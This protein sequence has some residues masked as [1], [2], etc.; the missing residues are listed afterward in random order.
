MN[1]KRTTLEIRAHWRGILL[2][3]LIVWLLL[4]SAY[5][6]AL[7]PSPG[8]TG[9]DFRMYYDAAARVMHREPLYV[10]EPS[11][12]TYVYSPVLALLL[13]PLVH[14]DYSRALQVWFFLAASC[15]GASVLLYALSARFRWSDLV[16]VGVTLIIG[17]RFW[18][19]TMNFGLGQVNFLILLAVCAMFLADSRGLLKTVALLIAGAA[20]IKTWM[21]G[22][23]IY[24]VL[25]RK[26]RAAALGGGAYVVLLVGSFSIVGWQEWPMFMKITTEYANQ[27]IGQ[28]ATT[29]SIPGFAYL[30]FGPNQHI[31]PLIASALI[32]RAFVLLG[33]VLMLAGFLHVRS[34]QPNQPSYEA[35][36]QLGFVILSL[37]LLLPMCQSEYFVL[38]LPLLWTLLAPPPV[39]GQERRL[40]MGVLAGTFLVY[41]VFTRAWPVPPIPEPYKHGI[42]SL[43]VSADFFA[44]LSLWVFTLYALRRLRVK[45]PASSI[46]ESR[47]SV[48]S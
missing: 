36:L 33:V 31:E 34:N 37:L 9:I 14:L 43:V 41:L 20:L 46:Q 32:S 7:A 6:S 10:Y 39:I 29:Q 40:S 48:M 42:R 21:I 4:S 22:L 15:L 30:H 8:V 27:S 12:A 2:L 13:R 26:W 3:F 5:R 24:L 35:R 45:K 19:S 18:P 17:F 44:A 38:C 1:P 28:I 25:R 16:L 47:I 11:G 23:L